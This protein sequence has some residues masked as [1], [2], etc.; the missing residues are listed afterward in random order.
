MILEDNIIQEVT[1]KRHVPKKINNYTKQCY[2]ELTG[3]TRY[4]K[5]FRIP[6]RTEQKKVYPYLTEQERL[7]YLV[8][9]SILPIL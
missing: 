8:T 5:K 3:N 7:E 2:K 1:S 9:P 6:P 4:E